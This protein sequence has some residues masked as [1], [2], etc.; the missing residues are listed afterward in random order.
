MDRMVL[1]ETLNDCASVDIE[2]LLDVIEM[3]RMVL[4]DALKNDYASVDIEDL[5]EHCSI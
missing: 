5:L 3:D 4:C 2:D 1:R